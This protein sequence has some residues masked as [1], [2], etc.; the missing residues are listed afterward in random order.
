MHK[1]LFPATL[2][3]FLLISAGCDEKKEQVRQEVKDRVEKAREV[4]EKVE[5][6]AK[7]VVKESAEKL[8]HREKNGMLAL[9]DEE[10]RQKMQD[11]LVELRR[12][13]EGLERTF[14][15]A[16]SRPDLFPDDKMA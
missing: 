1:M 16:R 15:Y 3:S 14:A 2:V 9:S 4:K 6:G 12:Y 8:L 11:D 13:D 7:T 10:F 5:D